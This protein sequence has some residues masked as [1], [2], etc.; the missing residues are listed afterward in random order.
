[1]CKTNQIKPS[2]PSGIHSAFPVSGNN[3]I[4]QFICLQ[5]NFGMNLIWNFHWF[6]CLHT[7]PLS[8]NMMYPPHF[9]TVWQIY[10]CY[11]LY[12]RYRK[13]LLCYLFA[14]KNTG[15][16]IISISGILKAVIPLA[17][18][19]LILER[20]HSACFAAISLYLDSV[21]GF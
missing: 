4:S 10:R 1:M 17:G 21:T 16:R 13:M 9:Q 19:G 6:C 18:I 8:V 14:K 5:F 7:K 2:F 11:Y 15:H 12:F 3:F 20:Y